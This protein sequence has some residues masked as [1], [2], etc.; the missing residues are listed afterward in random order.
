LKTYFS[1]IPTFA[2]PQLEAQEL[3]RSKL[4]TFFAVQISPQVICKIPW[5][6]C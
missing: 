6:N 3:F 2:R 5:R 4:V 1:P